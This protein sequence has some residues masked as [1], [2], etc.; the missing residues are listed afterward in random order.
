M[1]FLL[2]PK[3][4]SS[5]VPPSLNTIKPS[6][7]NF[8]VDPLPFIPPGIEIEDGGPHRV[9]RAV[10]HLFGNAVHA[11]EE[12]V[13]AVD[14]Q[15]ILDADDLQGFMNQVTDYI[16]ETFHIPVRSRCRHPFGIGLFQLDTTFHKDLLFAANPHN[17]GGIE[18]NFVSHD[19]ALNRRNWN[20]IRYGWIMLLGYPI[21]YRNLEHIDQAVAPFQSW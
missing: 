16:L 21:D 6:M 5:P 1:S 7:A 20:Y 8:P 13:L 4:H 17:I 11:H 19:H 3:Q 2:S 12:Y 9:P 10:V 15:Q 18:V 14:S